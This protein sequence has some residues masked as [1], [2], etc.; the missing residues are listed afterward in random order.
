M[1]CGLWIKMLDYIQSIPYSSYS[2]NRL[3]LNNIIKLIYLFLDFI[4]PLEK[5]MARL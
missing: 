3:I 5:E 4:D 2:V 1:P